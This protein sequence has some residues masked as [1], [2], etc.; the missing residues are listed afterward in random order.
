V[1]ILIQA[2]YIS[3]RIWHPSEIQLCRRVGTDEHEG[4]SNGLTQSNGSSERADIEYGDRSSHIDQCLLIK[5]FRLVEEEESISNPEDQPSKLQP[6]KRRNK[7]AYRCGSDPAGGVGCR[8]SLIAGVLFERRVGDLEDSKKK[9][10][11]RKCRI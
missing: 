7:S 11:P 1:V 4:T 10:P 9:F 3:S 5:A 6:I 2:L 8:N